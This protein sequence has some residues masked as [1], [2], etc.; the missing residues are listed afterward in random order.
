MDNVDKCKKEEKTQAENVE[1]F[2]YNFGINTPPIEKVILNFGVKKETAGYENP[3]G[4]LIFYLPKSCSPIVTTSPAPI[5]MSRSPSWQLE[6]RK[7]S[8]SSKVGK[9]SQGVPSSWIL[10]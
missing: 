8:I 10:F 1:Q 7:F 4:L 2:V 6:R 5:V 9:Y 3:D